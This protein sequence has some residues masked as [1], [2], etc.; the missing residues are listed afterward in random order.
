[1]GFGQGG[2]GNANLKRQKRSFV[3]GGA[4]RNGLPGQRARGCGAVERGNA[5]W[6][7]T[8]TAASQGDERIS[9]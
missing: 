1:M 5:V 6:A 2:T 7:G 3:R 4:K 8:G 9:L